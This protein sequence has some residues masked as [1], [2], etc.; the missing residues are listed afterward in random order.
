MNG[1]GTVRIS[2]AEGD[3]VQEIIHH[4]EVPTDRVAMAMV[5]AHRCPTDTAL[6]RGDWVIL[7]P[8]DVAALW[9]FL[10]LQNLGAESVFDF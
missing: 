1:D 4:L 7:I 9:R 8:A 5:N 2:L 10:G 3:T 6:R